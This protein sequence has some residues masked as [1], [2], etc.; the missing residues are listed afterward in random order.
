MTVKRT[1]PP[2]AEPQTG[3]PHD[4]DREGG[5]PYAK[6]VDDYQKG[7]ASPPEDQVGRD[8]KPGGI[9]TPSKN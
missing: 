9:R 3:L 8:T 2:G 7:V 6:E 1:P 5:Q 4:E